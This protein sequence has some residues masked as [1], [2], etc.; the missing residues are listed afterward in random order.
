MKENEIKFMSIHDTMDKYNKQSNVQHKSIL[1]QTLDLYYKD[2]EEYVLKK[3][4]WC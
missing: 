4:E 1:K 2:L 3:R